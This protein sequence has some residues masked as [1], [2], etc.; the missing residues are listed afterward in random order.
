M[1]GLISTRSQV[2]PLLTANQFLFFPPNGQCL[3]FAKKKCNFRG[4]ATL[5]HPPVFIPPSRWLTNKVVRLLRSEKNKWPGISGPCLLFSLLG[6]SA[7]TLLCSEVAQTPGWWMAPWLHYELPRERERD[8]PEKTRGT[9]LINYSR[10]QGGG[11]VPPAWNQFRVCNKAVFSRDEPNTTEFVR[12]WQ[13]MA[14][15]QGEKVKILR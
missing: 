4:P 6:S 3:K 13:I 5:T 15:W 12:K 9:A 1:V 8:G 14:V 11:G 10:A 2:R 7:W